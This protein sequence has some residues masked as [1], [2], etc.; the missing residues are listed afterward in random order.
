[1]RLLISGLVQARRSM[2]GRPGCVGGGGSLQMGLLRNACRAGLLGLAALAPQAGL[3]QTAPAQAGDEQPAESKRPPERDI[4]TVTGSRVP[5]KAKAQRQAKSISKMDNFY[6]EPLARFQDPVCP[7]VMGMIP[8]P[9]DA[10]VDRIRFNAERAGIRVARPGNCRINILVAFVGDGKE[11][12]ET[13][14]HKNGYMF[15]NLPNGD[16][17]ELARATGPVRTWSITSVRNRGGMRVTGSPAIVNTMGA[18]RTTL[19]I[20]KDIESSVVLI[21]GKSIVGMT[22]QQIADYVSMRTFALTR[23]PGDAA[24]LETILNLFEPAQMPPAELTLFD[25]SYL[26]SLYNRLPNLP[27]SAYIG[28]VGGL[29]RKEMK[30]QEDAAAAAAGAD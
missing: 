24:R 12:L 14:M 5:V 8:G 10:L 29:M 7:G 27:A 9:A 28:N 16:I 19:A 15:A 4:I 11:T 2:L 13:L 18:S 3:A 1:M 25:L 17:K 20:R 21:D 26:K 22:L 6:S 23:P 30:A